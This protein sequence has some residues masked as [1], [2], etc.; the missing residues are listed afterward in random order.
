M[1]LDLALNNALTGLRT[2]QQA[3]TTTSNNVSNANTEGY[4]RK[5]AQQVALVLA[6]QGAGVD[7]TDV[8]RQVND[9]L[10]KQL[11]NY[12]AMLGQ[13]NVSDDYYTRTQQIFGTLTSNSSL[14]AGLSDFNTTLQALATSPED[15]TRQAAVV[16]SAVALAQRFND[17]STSIQQLRAQADQDISAAVNSI[18]LDLGKVADLNTQIAKNY[19]NNLPVG[20]LLDQ[21][22]LALNDLSQQMDFSTFTRSN[23]EV[24]IVSGG[25]RVLLDGTAP[26]LTHNAVAAAD[27]SVTYPGAGIDGINFNGVDITTD[28]KSGKIAALVQMRDTTLPNL[29]AQID[30]LATQLSDQINTLHNDGTGFPAANSLT[31]TRTV[32]GADPVA[33]TGNVRIA[34]VDGSGKLV[35]AP[36]DL[37]LTTVADVTDVVNAVN[38]ALGANG[39]AAIVGGKLTI[40]A[41]N[42]ANAITINEDTSAI[43]TE[44]FS[45]YFGLNDFFVNP[46]GASPS[47]GIQVRNDIA[48][49]P[50][51]MSR[52]DLS[53]TAALAG[54]TAI[55]SG[56]NTIASQMAAIFDANIS[57][58]AAGGISAT[59]TT[60]GD[61]SGQ[62]LG[63]NATAA[64]NAKNT[65]DYQ[66]GL[67]AD[68]KNKADSVSGVNI[69]EEL[70]NLIKLQQNYGAVSRVITVTSTLMDTLIGI[71]R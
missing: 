52:G 13:L 6:G 71:V 19:A 7:I 25:G 44:G 22:D 50:A 11:R 64:G 58:G 32:A 47:K 16:T 41:T 37:D 38:A 68:V 29:Q 35:A 65:L 27:P 45:K 10:V 67:Y 70:A 60:L 20:D 36:L 21:R 49:T 5:T 33:G 3:L 18:N 24:V 69:D 4:T 17:S 14:T 9:A 12:S 57:F 59:T 62:I 2:V 54:D 51:L 42:P 39:T 1:S 23:G 43:G 55:T 30:E 8:T 63:L 31:G 15:P 66:Q 34:V 40:T 56:N 26:T 28:I 48:A 46:S 53:M 61:Y